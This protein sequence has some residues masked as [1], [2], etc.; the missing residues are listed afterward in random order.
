MFRSGI[1][2][3]KLHCS[4]QWM[5]TD[6]TTVDHYLK[7]G[8]YLASPAMIREK[9]PQY[10]QFFRPKRV[11]WLRDRVQTKGDK[12][13]HFN[14]ILIRLG[15]PEMMRATYPT[16]KCR[17][18]LRR[19]AVLIKAKKYI[20]DANSISITRH[21]IREIRAKEAAIYRKNFRTLSKNEKV[22]PQAALFHMDYKGKA[23]CEK[24]RDLAIIQ[25]MAS[26][27]DNQGHLAEQ[28]QQEFGI[29]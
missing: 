16:S 2:L 6:T 9:R 3:N 20:E 7:P 18:N 4:G 28:L 29:T 5:M 25:S 14:E 21:E 8:L 11:E 19:W 22:L 12:N 17:D 24:D 15:H 27:L 23:Q 13:H 10:K 1:D 26:E